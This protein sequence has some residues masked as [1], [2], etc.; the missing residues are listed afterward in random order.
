MLLVA[1]YQQLYWMIYKC[2]TEIN[3]LHHKLI[4]NL[5]TTHANTLNFLTIMFSL[6]SPH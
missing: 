6:P 1:I 2:G 4:Y 3:M 5:D